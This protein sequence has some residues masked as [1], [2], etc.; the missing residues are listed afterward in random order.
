MADDLR[1]R[2]WREFLRRAEFS[3]ASVYRHRCD[4]WPYIPIHPFADEAAELARVGI[5]PEG[6][7]SA[8]A[9]WGIE[10]DA[11]LVE[12]CITRRAHHPRGLYARRI[13][14]EEGWVYLLAVLDD[15]YITRGAFEA[16]L[17]RFA[18]LGFPGGEPFRLPRGSGL[19][20]LADIQ[21]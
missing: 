11:T 15:P 5:A 3:P 17:S 20:R 2:R 6:C 21:A 18:S 9:W 8:D 1:L 14:H 4:G 16:S 12:S 10:G 7:W 13:E 19:V